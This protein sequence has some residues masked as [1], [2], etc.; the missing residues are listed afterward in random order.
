MK[1]QKKGYEKKMK[2]K[3]LVRKLEGKKLMQQIWKMHEGGKGR[4]GEKSSF[5]KIQSKK[6]QDCFRKRRHGS[7]KTECG[8]YSSSA[9]SQS[10][11]ITRLKKKN[12]SV[13][14]TTDL[15][16]ERGR[17]RGWGGEAES[18][19][20]IITYPDREQIQGKKEMHVRVCVFN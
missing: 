2:G 3:N 16:E 10:T 18:A 13:P 14:N 6:T 17:S 1:C 19:R 20:G 9:L 12:S 4:F 11:H 7:Q 5:E 8:V 15:T